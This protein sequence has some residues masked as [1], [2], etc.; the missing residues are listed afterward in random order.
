MALVLPKLTVEDPVK[1]V[2]VMVTNVPPSVDP[3]DGKILVIMGLFNMT[4]ACVPMP[5]PKAFTP[6]TTNQ[7]VL[8]A[9]RFGIVAWLVVTFVARV[10]GPVP[11][12]VS[13]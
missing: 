8:P 6:S 4:L 13:K 3:I 11:G 10:P 7:Y 2:P 1:P 9:I 5:S 12:P